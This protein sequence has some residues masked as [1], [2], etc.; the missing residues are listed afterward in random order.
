MTAYAQRGNFTM[1]NSGL[2][3][4]LSE[5]DQRVLKRTVTSKKRT[6]TAKETAEL[7]QHSDFPLSK[8]TEDNTPINEAELVQSWFNE[9]E[10]EDKLLKGIFLEV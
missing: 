1:Q 6:T 3:V 7:S 10:D 9:H 5:R 8:I 2:K 4:K